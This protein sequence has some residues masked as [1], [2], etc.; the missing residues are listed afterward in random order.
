M[1]DGAVEAVV[2]EDITE[3]ME[4]EDWYSMS[5]RGVYVGDY[6]Y[7]INTVRDITAYGMEESF[8][9]SGRLELVR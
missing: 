1:E 2:A 4:G 6:F 8:V 5:L 3:D 9:E 7:I